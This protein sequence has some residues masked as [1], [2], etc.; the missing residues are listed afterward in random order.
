[1]IFTIIE[2]N[3][4]LSSEIEYYSAIRCNPTDVTPIKLVKMLSKVKK[5]D[6]VPD[7]YLTYRSQGKG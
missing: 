6:P 2:K 3:C 5:S 4:N 7:I 1:M